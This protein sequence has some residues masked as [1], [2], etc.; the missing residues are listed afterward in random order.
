MNIYQIPA[1]SLNIT[2]ADETVMFE[3]KNETDNA[4]EN[5]LTAKKEEINHLDMIG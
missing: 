4:G 2:L 1:L 3:E 5:K